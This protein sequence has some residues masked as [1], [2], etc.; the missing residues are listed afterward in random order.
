MARPAQGLGASHS[1]RPE[2]KAE[3]AQ[4]PQADLDQLDRRGASTTQRCY[5]EAQ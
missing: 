1:E 5:R 3:G 4:R 2:R